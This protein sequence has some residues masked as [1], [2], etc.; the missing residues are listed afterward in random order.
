LHP[1]YGFVLDSGD[2]A[3][4]GYIL[5]APDSKEFLS[6]Y[7]S[8]YIPTLDQVNLPKPNLHVP[9]QW[10]GDDLPTALLQ[11]LY[12]PDKSILHAE[13]PQLLEQY[14]AHLHIDVL[15][16]YQRQGYGRKLMREYLRKLR[17]ENIKGV[18]L[19]M[20]GDNFGAETFYRKLGFGRFPMILDGGESGELG[21]ERGNR[22]VWLVR[23]L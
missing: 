7:H 8:E 9:A 10:V 4:I 20:A 1:D 18:H 17:D 5:G 16:E 3:A 13:F 19:V 23:E 21:R 2:G 12:A 22:N 14:P 15:P 11:L 6:R